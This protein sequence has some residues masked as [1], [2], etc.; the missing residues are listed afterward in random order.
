MAETET[1]NQV[2]AVMRH[3]Y[4]AGGTLF[5]IL[6]TLALIPQ[7]KVAA[8]MTSLHQIGDAVNQITGALSAMWIILGPLAIGLAA[9]GA[10]FAASFRS[11]LKSVTSQAAL[12]SNLEQKKE[13]ISATANLPEVEKVVSPPLATSI[14]NDKVVTS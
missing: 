2:N 3:A 10:A 5:T 9:K 1:Q 8:L 14:P 12:P 11:Q 4:T 7:E 13:M 6:A